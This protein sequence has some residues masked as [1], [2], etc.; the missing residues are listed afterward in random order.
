LVVATV[1]LAAAGTHSTLTAA[2]TT[3]AETAISL[4]IFIIKYLLIVYGEH[5]ALAL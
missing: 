3:A 2:I 4:F 5:G 1:V